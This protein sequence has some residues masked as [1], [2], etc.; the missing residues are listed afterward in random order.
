MRQNPLA[1]QTM[2]VWRSKAQGRRRT[3]DDAKFVG[4]VESYCEVAMMFV[5]ALLALAVRDAMFSS[6]RR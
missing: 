4:P 1:C 2:R 3:D 6:W 5:E